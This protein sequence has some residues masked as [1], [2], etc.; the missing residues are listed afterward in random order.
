MTK[1]NYHGLVI[2]VGLLSSPR[3]RDGSDIRQGRW[4]NPR[5]PPPSRFLSNRSPTCLAARCASRCSIALR[6]AAALPTVIPATT[7]SAMDSQR[8]R[9]VL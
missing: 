6:G 4:L 7:P 2:V 1:A 5:R 9:D 3:H 8:G